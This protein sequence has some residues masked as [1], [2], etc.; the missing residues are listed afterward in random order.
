M[1]QELLDGKLKQF[2]L[3]FLEVTDQEV[4][5]YY[6]YTNEK[7]KISLVQFKPENFKKSIKPDQASLKDI[8]RTTGRN[9][10]SPKRSN[11]PIS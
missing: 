6:T 10:E 8:L 7:V 2:L 1:A 11:L 4:L 3:A 5:D 9:T